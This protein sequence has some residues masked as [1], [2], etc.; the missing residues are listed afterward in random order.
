[1]ANSATTSHEA[2]LQQFM[3]NERS[4]RAYLR[5]I[6]ASWQ[7]VDEAMQ[8]TS[9]VAWRKYAEFE[10]NSNF[11]A[12]LAIIARF[13]ALKIRRSKH[14]DRLVFCDRVLDLLED[15]GVGDLGHLEQRRRVLERCVERLG[16]AQRRLLV[17]AYGS[18]LKLREVAVKMGRSVEAFYKSVQRLRSALLA[19]SERELE[20]EQGAS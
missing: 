2:F 14:R 4:V 8:E 17:A 1:M 5:T 13:E 18:G 15:E 6:L 20:Q 16:D 7:D 12:W 3:R 19:C 10:P 11:G 9:M